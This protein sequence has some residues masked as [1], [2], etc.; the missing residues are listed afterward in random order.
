MYSALI[1]VLAV[2][3]LQPYY[4]LE[5]IQAWSWPTGFLQCFDT[6]GLVIWPVKIVPKMTYS[7]L[8]GTLSLY[9]TT[10]TKQTTPSP[11]AQPHIEVQGL[12][13]NAMNV[14]RCLFVT[15]LQQ[16]QQTVVSWVWGDCLAPR[17][18][19]LNSCAASLTSTPTH[20]GTVWFSFWF[21]F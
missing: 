2:I 10:T 8:G 1:V 19:T 17:C 21:I 14:L 13:Q 3:N 6:V 5:S 18:S 20:S 11:F 9:T 4:F 7:A 15:A 12:R 16:W